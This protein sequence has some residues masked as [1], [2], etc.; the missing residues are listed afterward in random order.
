MKHQITNISILQTSKIV[1]IIYALFGLIFVPFSCLFIFLGVISEE[2]VNI[3]VGVLYLFMPLLY[4]VG[5]FVFSVL[6][7]W[8]YNLVAERIGG[9]EFELSEVEGT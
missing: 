8:I 6:A 3:F 2:P 7:I 1:A 4:A 5:G 9:I